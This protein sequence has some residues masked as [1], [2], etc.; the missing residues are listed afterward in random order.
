VSR[1]Y[2][3]HPLPGVGA[4]IIRR[5][6]ILLVQRAR[7]PLKGYWSL[8]GGLIEPGEKIEDALKRE[9]R[10]ETGLLVRPRKMVEIFERIMP[11]AEGRTEYHY[12]LH[13]YLCTVVGG[14]LLAGDDAANVAWVPRAKLP[15]LHLTE[16]TLTVIERA[17]QLLSDG[18]S[19]SS[20]P[21]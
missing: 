7:D 18:T 1:R 2:P 3:K 5:A 14:K 6:S 9:V 4:L 16:G 15:T 11:D 20:L 17:F 19:L 12:I 10:E 21:R 8:P 13:D